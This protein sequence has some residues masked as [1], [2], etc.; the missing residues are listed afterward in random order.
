M[1]VCINIHVCMYVSIYMYVCMYQYTAW[2][3]LP[4]NSVVLR[5]PPPPQTY[6]SNNT[7]PILDLE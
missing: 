5:T 3:I 7:I 6:T 2:D 4:V 1:Y